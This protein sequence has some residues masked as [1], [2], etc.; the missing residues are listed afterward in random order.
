MTKDNDKKKVS[1]LLGGILF[2]IIISALKYFMYKDITF[3]STLFIFILG[4]LFGL[5]ALSK[6]TNFLKNMIF[7]SVIFIPLWIWFEPISL[8]GNI[9]SVKR[10]EFITLVLLAITFTWTEIVN[11]ILRSHGR[12]PSGHM[13]FVANI[14]LMIFLFTSGLMDIIGAWMSDNWL[15]TI[16]F[17]IVWWIIISIFIGLGISRLYKQY[18]KF[19]TWFVNKLSFKR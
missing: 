8:S 17:L 3:F 14:A 9:Y 19:M 11:S 18:A 10:V 15:Y 12:Q 2:T 1:F 6:E 16:L 5:V 4:G 13:G 7:A